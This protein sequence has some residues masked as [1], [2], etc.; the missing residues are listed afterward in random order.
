[1]LTYYVKAS[2][3]KA[4]TIRFILALCVL[5]PRNM[6]EAAGDFERDIILDL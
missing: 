1:M 3:Q 2:P 5:D 6:Y 4:E